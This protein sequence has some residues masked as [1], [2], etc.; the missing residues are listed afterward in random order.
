MKKNK[1]LVKT[2]CLNALFAAIYVALVLAFGDLSFGF[3]NG[4]ISIRVAEALIPLVCFNYKFIPGA[5][6]GCFISNLF[7]GNPLDI[8]LGTFQTTLS[9]Y[10]LHK[11][12]NKHISLIVASLLCGIIIGLELY[13]L[14]FS[15]IGLWVILTTFIG[16]YIIL[17]AGYVLIKKLNGVFK[18]FK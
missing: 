13:F 10:A 11:I 14:G 6:L 7:G 5:I 16:E 17:L 4:L 3:A 1:D 15:V 18:I 12:K 2:M 9:V 8:L